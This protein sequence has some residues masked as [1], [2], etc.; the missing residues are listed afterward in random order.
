MSITL[1]TKASGSCYKPVESKPVREKESFCNCWFY[2]ESAE[3]MA[4]D[5]A[6]VDQNNAAADAEQAPA[7]AL[8]ALLVGG[9]GNLQ[10]LL[11]IPDACLLYTSDAADE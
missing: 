2:K 4:A 10:A 5:A 7:N 11:N 9:A 8:E 1:C 3:D 6:A